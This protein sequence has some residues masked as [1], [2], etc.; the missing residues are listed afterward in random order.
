V[1]NPVWFLQGSA[2]AELGWGGKF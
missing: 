1:Y 2:A